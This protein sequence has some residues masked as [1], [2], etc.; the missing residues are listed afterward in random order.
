VSLTIANQGVTHPVATISGSGVVGSKIQIGNKSFSLTDNDVFY[1]EIAVNKA[2][3]IDWSVSRTAGPAPFTFVVDGKSCFDPEGKQ[4]TYKIDFG[5]GI[6]SSSDSVSHTY[7]A[8]GNYFVKFKITDPE[9]VTSETGT[10]ISV[11]NNSFLPNI[12]PTVSMS[13]PSSNSQFNDNTYIDL[14]VNTLDVDGY[15]SKID[16]FATNTVSPFETIKIFTNDGYPLVGKWLNPIAGVWDI[17]AEVYD[18]YNLKATSSK[19]RITVKHIDITQLHLPSELTNA[20]IF[21]NPLHDTDLYLNCPLNNTKYTI[22]NLAGMN[23]KEGVAQQ[24]LNILKLDGF[25][26]GIYIISLTNNHDKINIKLI[27]Q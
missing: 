9:G 20:H 26:S 24:G 14:K 6:V 1:N 3:R 10:Q 7:T 17:Y 23:I 22:S 4:L 27:V 19:K 13:S 8:E 2:P 25:K 16:Y 18:N 5:D 12:P 15:I 21:P 11:W